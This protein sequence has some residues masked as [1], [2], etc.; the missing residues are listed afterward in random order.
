MRKIPAV[1]IIA[2]AAI[3]ASV[4]PARASIVTM[5]FQGTLP[6][7]N[8]SGTQVNVSYEGTVTWDST[9]SPYLTGSG[10]AVYHPVSETFILESLVLTNYISSASVRMDINNDQLSFSF[11]FS[12][13]FSVPA[14]SK[15]LTEFEGIL[16]GA[17]TSLALPSD[18]SF[19]ISDFII[20]SF[21][22]HSVAILGTCP[23]CLPVVGT[24]FATAS[25]SNPP[26]SVPEPA[27]VTLLGAGL[28]FTMVAARR[29][30]SKM[31]G[32]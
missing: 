25:A 24:L 14:I 29:R 21:A 5:D 16:V 15:P 23:D 26:S 13:G 6:L 9:A 32:R 22:Y 3:T 2:L 12:P 18:T 17:P 31:A 30:R 8:T 7:T 4:A 27:S 19:I 10:F 20:Q 11:D 28:L 1:I